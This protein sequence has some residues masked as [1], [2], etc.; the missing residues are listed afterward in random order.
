MVAMI[1]MAL[2]SGIFL[3]TLASV[4]KSVAETDI[5]TRS[6]T[7]SRLALQTLD[8]E[9]RSGNL[10]YDP[11]S[12]TDLTQRYYR[13]KVYTQANATARQPSPR[14]TCRLWRITDTNELQ[15]RWWEPYPADPDATAS[16]WRTVATGVVNL[17]VDPEEPAFVL[18]DDPNKGGRTV[19]VVFL[20]NEDLNGDLSTGTVRVQSS[21]T[22]RNTSCRFSIGVCSDEPTD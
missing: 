12:Y 4:Q 22:G 10:L 21:L 8:H 6:N 3:T 2:A 15:T 16:E 13:F 9:V 18:D 17:A 20:V 7:Q 19:N 5:R 11:E 1:V 14:Y